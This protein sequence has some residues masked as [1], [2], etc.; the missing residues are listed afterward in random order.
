L[1]FLPFNDWVLTA[2]LW[3][4]VVFAEIARFGA[5]VLV[6]VAEVN[7]AVAGAVF[8]GAGVPA[9]F[10]APETCASDETQKT[11]KT[12]IRDIALSDDIS[13]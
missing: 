10:A 12:N 5:T 7:F 2:G 8:F 3:A 11:A 9:A 13:L 6:G 4:T 1:A